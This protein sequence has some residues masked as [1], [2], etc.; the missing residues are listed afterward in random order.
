MKIATPRYTIGNV[1]TKDLNLWTRTKSLQ[2]DGH[3]VESIFRRGL[4][5]IEQDEIKNMTHNNIS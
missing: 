4:E 3:T 5:E 2:A 1:T